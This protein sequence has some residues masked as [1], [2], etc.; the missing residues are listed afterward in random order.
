[1]AK[2]VL[3]LTDEQIAVLLARKQLT[4]VEGDG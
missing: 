1:M 4:E 2:H 3:A